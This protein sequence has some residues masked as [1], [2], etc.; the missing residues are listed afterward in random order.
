MAVARNRVRRGNDVGLFSE[1]IDV[2][3]GELLGNFPQALTHIALLTAALC[4][5]QAEAGEA[6]PRAV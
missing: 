6:Q 1:E 2:H 5:A 3:T 4:L